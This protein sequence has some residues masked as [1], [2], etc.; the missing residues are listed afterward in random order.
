M[1]TR[2]YL[3]VFLAT[4]MTPLAVAA[5]DEDFTRGPGARAIIRSCDGSGRFIGRAFLSERP[6]REGVKLVDV[7]LYVNGLTPGKHAVHIHEA[8]AC[9]PTCAAALGHFDP[10]PAGHSGAPAPAPSPN[11]VEFNHPYH[12]GDL[13][14]VLVNTNGSGSMHTTTSRVTLSAGPL[15][16]FDISTT[17][18]GSS[19]IIHDL[20]DKYCSPQ[21]AGCAGGTRAACGV[22]VRDN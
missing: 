6:S 21:A 14:N 2:T 7:S 9:T 19:I 4:A 20:E 18:P 16:V 11:S 1:R 22:I 15:S 13:I 3:W 8:G 17:A 12:S 10:G 5:Q